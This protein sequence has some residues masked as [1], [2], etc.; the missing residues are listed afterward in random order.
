MQSILLAISEGTNVV[1]ALAWSI[2]DNLEWAQ[3]Y[4]SRFGI[5]YCNFTSQERA[6]KSSAF[7]FVDAFR[8]Y[9]AGAYENSSVVQEAF[10]GGGG[11]GTGGR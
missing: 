11:N 6:W 4:Q 10:G 2:M 3:G 8:V 1:G 7:A 9:G 5:Q